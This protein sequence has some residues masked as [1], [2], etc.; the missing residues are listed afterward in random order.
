MIEVR[1]PTHIPDLRPSQQ[2]QQKLDFQEL[3]KVSMATSKYVKRITLFKIAK[4]EDVS[5]AVEKY[6]TLRES[7]T[8]VCCRGPY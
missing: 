6:K 8:K 5:A 4:D 3:C 1:C 2:N 7:A